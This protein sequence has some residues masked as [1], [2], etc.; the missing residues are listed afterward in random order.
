MIKSASV[1]S[2]RQS[3]GAIRKLINFFRDLSTLA[4][5]QC[6]LFLTD[7]GDEVRK[8]R[9]G[10][11][12]LTLCLA[13]SASCLPLA[14]AGA[15][16]ILAESMHLSVGQALLSLAF[17]GLVAGCGGGYAAACWI[18]RGGAWMQRSRAECRLNMSWIKDTLNHLGGDSPIHSHSNSRE[19]S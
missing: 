5:L 10:L 11:V 7:A 4:E 15:A 18:C 14:L 19:P 9:T 12:L 17:G 13:V 16:L 2:D 1:R 8:A 3:Q 6:L